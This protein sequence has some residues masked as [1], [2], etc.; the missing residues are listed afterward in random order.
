MKNWKKIGILLT[1][2]VLFTTSVEAQSNNKE[3]VII[4][5]MEV[6]GA[7]GRFTS[8]MVV[9]KP[10]GEKYVVELK[11][12]SSTSFGEDAGENG[13]TIQTEILKWSK[14][15]FEITSFSTDGGEAFTRTFIIMTK[16]TN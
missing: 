11:K 12:G 16:E 7:Q 10:D 9:I 6:Y 8:E 15:G 1:L 2:F 4:R 14:M 13:I 3:L 5:T